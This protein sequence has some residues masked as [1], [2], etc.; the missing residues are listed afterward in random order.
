VQKRGIADYFEPSIAVSSKFSGSGGILGGTAIGKPG[1]MKQDRTA[2]SVDTPIPPDTQPDDPEE[3]ED[4]GDPKLVDNAGEKALSDKQAAGKLDKA[5]EAATGDRQKLGEAEQ[6]DRQQ[7]NSE[8]DKI[9]AAALAKNA[10]DR[11][12]RQFSAAEFAL[13]QA[14]Q[15]IPELKSLAENLIVDRTP[16]GLRIQLVDQDK[17]SMFPS[18]SFDMAEPAKKLMALVSQVV[19]RLPNKVSLSGHT[20]ATPFARTGN[21]GNW[22]L[23]TD[24]ANA[25]RRALLAAGLPA[26]RVVKVVGVADRDPLVAD[27]PTSPRNRRISIVLLKD[28]K[29]PGSLA[30]AK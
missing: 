7:F 14:I 22:E 2:P 4:S 3:S 23:S 12:E 19:Q 18:G 30:Q 1:S 11:E 26:D 24:R 5:G 17:L 6:G 20:D 25:S 8:L 27:Q 16:E 10:V 13:R 29:P 9:T 28:P 21:Y 15:D